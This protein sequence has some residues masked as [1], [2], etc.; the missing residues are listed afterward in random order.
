MCIRD[1]SKENGG[2]SE[3]ATGEVVPIAV[4]VNQ[5]IE[6]KKGETLILNIGQ[7]IAGYN[8]I[9]VSGPAGTQVLSLIHILLNAV[10]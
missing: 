2:T 6:I 7:N 5:P 9:T 4:D 10:L 3:Y 8:T 1:R